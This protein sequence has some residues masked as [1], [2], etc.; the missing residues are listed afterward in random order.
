MTKWLRWQGIVVF[1]V[2][3]ILFFSF[4]SFGADT[5]VKRSIEKA[6]TRVVG[7]R[8]ELADV[9]VH[10][11]PL[12]ITLNS[13]QLQQTLHAALADVS[14]FSVNVRVTGPLDHYKVKMISDLDR[15]LKNALGRQIKDLTN[16]FQDNLQAGILGKVKG[17]M[18]DMSGSMSGLDSITQEI[19]SRLSLGNDVS[20]TPLKSLGGKLK[21]VNRNAPAYRSG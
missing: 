2:V 6:G 7:A 11:F 16:E 20:N 13:N 12:G 5:I 15:V 8:V 4:W 17:P 21:I 1:G 9:D 18:A 10:L 14:R 19:S 3:S